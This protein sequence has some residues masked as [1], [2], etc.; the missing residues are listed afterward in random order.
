[1]QMYRENQIVKYRYKSHDEI[2]GNPLAKSLVTETVS[3]YTQQICK[4]LESLISPIVK[5]PYFLELF[6]K[7]YGKFHSRY[8]VPFHSSSSLQTFDRERDSGD[9]DLLIF[10]NSKRLRTQ[11]LE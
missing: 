8:I 3:F 6:N 11:L 5:N 9:I 2:E 10:L 1:M 4:W 7:F